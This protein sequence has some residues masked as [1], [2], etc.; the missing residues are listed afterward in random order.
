MVF[1]K[2]SQQ[3]QFF[4]SNYLLRDASSNHVDL[5]PSCFGRYLDTTYHVIMVNKVLL[6]LILTMEFFLI[7]TIRYELI[8]FPLLMLLKCLRAWSL[9]LDRSLLLIYNVIL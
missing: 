1:S 9:F 2:T 4:T 6:W 3:Y 7:L 5:N 8:L